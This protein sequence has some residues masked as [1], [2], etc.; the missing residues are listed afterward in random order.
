MPDLLK[1]H[2]NG[3]IAAEEDEESI[4]DALHSINKLLWRAVEDIFVGAKVVHLPESYYTYLPSHQKHK[5]KQS[6]SLTMVRFLDFL[7]QLFPVFLENYAPA[8][9]SEEDEES[10]ILELHPFWLPSFFALRF[11]YPPTVFTAINPHQPGNNC[12]MTWLSIR[13]G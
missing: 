2:L 12:S 8:S 10:T 7:Q 3:E 11:L 6:F 5:A 13:G 1:E 9:D 4:Q